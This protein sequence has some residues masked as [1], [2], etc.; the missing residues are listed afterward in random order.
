[1]SHDGELHVIAAARN[2]LPFLE[3]T[4][5]LQGSDVAGLG[6]A[7]LIRHA[8]RSMQRDDVGGAEQGDLD[9][10]S[11]QHGTAWITLRQLVGKGQRRIENVEP[12]IEPA[13]IAETCDTLA[14]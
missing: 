7:K 4:R 2:G 6:P 1:M 14:A 13:V 8:V 12:A 5:G 10:R 11:N 9:D 3:P